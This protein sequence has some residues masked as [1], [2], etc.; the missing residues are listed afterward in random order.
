MES[1]EHFLVFTNDYQQTWMGIFNRYKLID[2]RKQDNKKISK[3]LFIDID[4]LLKNN[5]VPLE[6]ISFFAANQGPGPFTTLRSIIASINGLAF[7]QKKPIVGLHGIEVFVQEQ[8]DPTCDYTIVLNNAFSNDVYYA[9]LDQKNQSTMGCVSFDEIIET[10]NKLPA[11]KIKLV[12]SIIEEKKIE[13]ANRIQKYLVIPQECPNAPTLDAMGKQAY[14]QWQ[15]GKNIV[16]E[17]LP[18]YFKESSKA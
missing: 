16:N 8:Y 11:E 12:G 15:G 14:H 4:L 1:H 17:L 6:T 10:I 3:L 2:F 13:L 18:L 7:A 9:I 5:N